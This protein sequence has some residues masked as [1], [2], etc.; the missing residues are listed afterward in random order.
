[1]HRSRKSRGDY[2]RENGIERK[3]FL[4]SFFY[5]DM[6]GFYR[7]KGRFYSINYPHKSFSPVGEKRSGFTF[8]KLL[9]KDNIKDVEWMC[10]SS[11]K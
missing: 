8:T 10:C 2:Y 11:R 3:S 4:E 7:I 1:M 5:K 9:C 6:V